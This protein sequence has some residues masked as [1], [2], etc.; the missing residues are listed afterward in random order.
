MSKN[1]GIV[2]GNI[3][4]PQGVL[5][6]GAI[7]HQDGIITKILNSTQV[8]DH[9]A[10]NVGSSID[11]TGK[12]IL[13]GGI[14]AHVHCFSDPRE[15][16]RAATMSAAAGGITTIIDMPYDDGNPVNNLA[17]VNQ[18]I[19]EI[20]G[21]A[22]V[23]VALHGTVAPGSFGSELQSMVDAGICGF[24]V[25]MFET[26]KNRFPRISND[27]LYEILKTS[28]AAGVVVGV[29]A[30]DGEIIGTMIETL[31][32][33]GQTEPIAHCLSRPP[34]SETVSIAAGVAIAEAAEAPFHIF[35]ASLPESIDIVVAARER[36]ADISVETCP[37]YLLFSGDDMNSLG[38]R[39]KINPP[40]RSKESVEEL[41][42]LLALGA[43]DMF[44]SDHAP[45]RLDKKSDAE[46]IFNNSSGAPGVQLLYPILLS[47][48]FAKG[49]LSLNR[50]AELMASG[51][52]NR[53][54]LGHRKGHLAPGYDADFVVY[55]P[56]TQWTV[57][58][59]KQHS[60]AG[61]TPY[62]G[63]EMLGKIE[64]TFLRGVCIAAEEELRSTAEV[65]IF[66]KGVS[67]GSI[68]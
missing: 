30:E 55:D 48:G 6:G 35:H 39:G 60:L 20:P 26:D 67:N 3:V 17:R 51:P 44:T 21:Q 50:V 52:A 19:S 29:H 43:V 28:R 64:Q 8:V 45:W 42:E 56:N 27:E 66:I 61:W 40:L 16:F 14:D 37:H 53:F 15:G 5:L 7:V 41:W 63:R 24:K 22:Y 2:V 62:E 18:K 13:P 57:S 54:N 9:L 59:E 23:D 25:S 68:V 46:N 4:T 10:S 38:A 65:G 32:K 34:V 1:S 36:G 12:Y 47:E 11:A 58:A 49:R 33:A 31:V